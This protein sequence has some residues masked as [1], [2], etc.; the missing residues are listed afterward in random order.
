MWKCRRTVGQAAVDAV[1]AEIWIA[2]TDSASDSEFN[3]RF[4]A[5]L[6]GVRPPVGPCLATEIER[7]RLPRL[8]RRGGMQPERGSP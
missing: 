3:A 6:A 7:R 8:L 2:T 1:L 4:G 5:A